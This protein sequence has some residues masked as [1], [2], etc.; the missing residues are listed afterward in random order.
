MPADLTAPQLIAI[1]RE[2]PGACGML[3]LTTNSLGTIEDV[4]VVA[5]G[6]RI[7]LYGDD[8]ICFAVD[9]GCWL[10][11]AAVERLLELGIELPKQVSDGW[12]CYL[13]AKAIPF[14]ETGQTSF[15]HAALAA[16]EQ[17]AKES[18]Q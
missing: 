2:H 17:H 11:G 10:T 16:L 3:R 15:L 14:S 8:A 18:K 9:F 13:H 12:R 6:G 7:S 4:R 1:L 5:E